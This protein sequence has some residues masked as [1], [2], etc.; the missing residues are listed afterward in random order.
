MK[1]WLY[2]FLF[3]FSH[4][5]CFPQDTVVHIAKI[6]SDGIVLDKGWKFHAGDD[7]SW[8]NPAFDDRNWESIN[9][10]LDI[11]HIAQFQKISIG[12][13]RLKLEG[14]SSLMDGGYLDWPF[15]KLERQGSILMAGFYTGSVLLAYHAEFIIV[16]PC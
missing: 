14:D 6:P 9:T 5:F 3:Q 1:I 10:D 16:L 11:K 7:S 8:A 4:H 12:W 13:L 2:L 15:H